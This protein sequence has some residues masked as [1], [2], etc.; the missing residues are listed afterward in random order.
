MFQMRPEVLR[1]V[2]AEIGIVP[3]PD[4]LDWNIE[5]FHFGK[6][7][8]VSSDFLEELRR[9]LR[10]RRAG[11]RLFRETIVDDRTPECREIRALIFRK[12]ILEYLL[13]ELEQPGE[14]LGTSRHSGR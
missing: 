14:L 13:L 9:H 7:F 11:T 1:H 12:S 10:E 6:A 4:E 3:S 8:S 2:C 5:R